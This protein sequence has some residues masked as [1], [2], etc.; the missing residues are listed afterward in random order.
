MM[1]FHKLIYKGFNYFDNRGLD[2]IGIFLSFLKSKS[3]TKKIL[4]AYP[5]IFIMGPARSG[6][7]VIYQSII[8]SLDVCYFFN[9]MDSKLFKYIPE[10]IAKIAKNYNINADI[11]FTSYYGKTEGFFG[12]SQG[13]NI[14][15]RWFKIEKELNEIG[16][17]YL[18]DNDISEM[19]NTLNFITNLS[20]VPF[21]NKWNGHNVHL[22][23]LDEVFPNAVYLRVK[24]DSVLN[25]QS[26]LIG[27]R[28][29]KGDP[30]RNITRSPRRYNLYKNSNYIE[31]VCGY[32][33]EMN[34]ELDEV[35]NKIDKEKIITIEYE[36]FCENPQKT[37]NDIV[38]K[39]EI[40]TGNK[41]KIK[42]SL[43]N[44][45]IIS[46]NRKISKDEFCKLKNCINEIECEVNMYA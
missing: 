28:E 30:Y 17:C 29:L 45:F 5:P 40:I 26:V 46:N 36:S 24:R 3:N 9:I 39:Y 19:R 41:L 32:I 18:S 14:W 37:I 20:R 27:R 44:K 10:Y 25:A 1:N 15:N 34:R 6:T 13:I 2:K 42:N 38:K 4:L 21:V 16:K 43:N 7:T 12:P 33:I 8:Y 22:L 35:S 23:T 11:K 31:Q